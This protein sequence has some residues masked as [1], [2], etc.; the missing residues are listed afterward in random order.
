MLPAYGNMMGAKIHSTGV[1]NLMD[2]AGADFSSSKSTVFR[3]C[4]S[5]AWC[6]KI[7]RTYVNI[8]DVP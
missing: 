1:C 7:R 2:K 6:F 3:R 5:P 8:Q 4:Y